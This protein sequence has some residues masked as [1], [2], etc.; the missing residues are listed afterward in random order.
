MEDILS[1]F[2]GDLVGRLH[3][4]LT[5]RLFL[6]PVM[7]ILYAV[8]DGVEDA[9]EGRPAYFWAI[10]TNPSER[11]RLLHEGWKAVTRVILLGVVM[12][13]LYQLI[14]FRWVYP[15]ELVIVVLLL[16]FIPYLLIRGPVNRIARIW[17]P[18]KASTR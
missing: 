9:R 11:G 4:P 16:A 18:R 5:F 15:M 13:V 6:Q 2:W 1:R 14:V 8:R 17:I 12:E 7:A 3:G 10:F